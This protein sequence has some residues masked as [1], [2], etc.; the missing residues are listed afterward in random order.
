MILLIVYRIDK[1]IEDNSV[2]KVIEERKSNP[3][4]KETNNEAVK[5]NELEKFKSGR[6]IASEDPETTQVKTEANKAR[7]DT[8]KI[9]IMKFC[10]TAFN[11]FRCLALK[12]FLQNQQK[13][14]RS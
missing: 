12:N 8:I 2:S 4:G 14:L 11:V 1:L 6:N 3:E 10:N 7:S 13:S 9:K 5:K